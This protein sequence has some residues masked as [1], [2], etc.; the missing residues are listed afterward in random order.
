MGTADLLLIFIKLQFFVFSHTNTHTQHQCTHTENTTAK[1]EIC[2]AKSAYNN[3]VVC[4]DDPFNMKYEIF[5]YLVVIFF[6]CETN[7][8]KNTHYLAPLKCSEIK[9]IRTLKEK[10][11]KV[12]LLFSILALK[13]EK[14]S[15]DIKLYM[16]NTL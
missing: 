16:Q 7:F 5:I 4:T 11:L 10:L 9:E 14:C 6:C 1:L 13:V 15:E 8:K 2:A 3:P 12:K